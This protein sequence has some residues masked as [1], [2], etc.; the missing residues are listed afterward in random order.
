MN[1]TLLI[2]FD[3]DGV[4]LQRERIAEDHFE[5]FNLIQMM[6]WSEGTASVRVEEID[7]HDVCLRCYVVTPVVD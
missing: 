3:A 4:E 7:A 6:L 2:R 1:T 5:I